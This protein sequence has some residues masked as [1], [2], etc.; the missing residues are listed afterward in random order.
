MRY[1]TLGSREAS[2]IGLGA[3]QIGT[4]YWGWGT[5]FG[6]DNVSA[7]LEAA[8]D[9]G[10]N[11]IDTAEIY[12][13]GESERQLGYHIPPDDEHFLIASKASPWHLTVS[14]IRRAA[15]NS[16]QRL[17]RTSMHLYQVH[18]PNIVIPLSRTMAGMR[19]LQSET[20]IS[21]VGVSNFSL[22]R[23]QRAERALGAPVITNQVDYS[24]LRPRAF[25]ALR[26][27]LDDGHVMIAYSPMAMGLLSGKY[28]TEQHPTGSRLQ[29]PAFSGRNYENVRRVLD[30]MESI[31][32]NHTAM[33][34]Q[35]AL[36]WVI[37]H[38]N[39]MAIPGAKSP[40][41]VR[42]NAA[43][44]DIQLSESEVT[45][46]DEV[47]STY[48][49]ALHVPRPFEVAKWLVNRDKTCADDQ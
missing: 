40:E 36:A 3:W 44:A 27:M 33:V 29:L 1:I 11:L 49:P 10:I 8:R 45:A 24:L 25:T 20:K 15:D 5:E 21:H 39:V 7:L 32:K 31:A 14:G 12:G 13:Q 23:W 35:I 34:S 4:R 37:A 16:L 19:T 18:F 47:A 41:Q 30:V 42:Q 22:A 46:L 17:Q 9:A 48:K 38:P 26:P 2:V 6:P 43:A 28:N